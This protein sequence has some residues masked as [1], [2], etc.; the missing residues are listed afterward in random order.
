[1]LLSLQ[2]RHDRVGPRQPRDV[3]LGY[4]ADQT[5]ALALEWLQATNTAGYTG[6]SCRRGGCPKRFSANGCGGMKEDAVVF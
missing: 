5:R 1:M 3:R 4:N 2:L 6:D